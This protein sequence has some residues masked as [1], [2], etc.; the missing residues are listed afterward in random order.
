MGPLEFV[1]ELGWSLVRSGSP[2]RC[3]ADQT[4]P[5]S[6]LSRRSSASCPA[7]DYRPEACLPVHLRSNLLGISLLSPRTQV[8]RR[9]A[10]AGQDPAAR[11]IEDDPQEPRVADSR[12]GPRPDHPRHGGAPVAA[13]AGWCPA[14]V[15]FDVYG[16]GI[17]VLKIAS[18]RRHVS[19]PCQGRS[20]SFLLAATWRSGD[21]KPMDPSS[22]RSTAV[23]ATPGGETTGQTQT[24]DITVNSMSAWTGI[25]Y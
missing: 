4:A 15:H 16:F 1:P 2:D 6:T 11:V 3:A 10:G 20:A 13:D 18:G 17:V 12:R 22:S 21:A 14:G 24:I 9:N 7:P 8:V 19:Q 25:R 5:C 23:S